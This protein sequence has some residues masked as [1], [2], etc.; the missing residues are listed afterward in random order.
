MLPGD[1]ERVHQ[2]MKDSRPPDAFELLHGH[3]RGMYLGFASEGGGD[4]CGSS[5]DSGGIGT[6][7]T[8]RGEEIVSCPASDVH[9]S[10]LVYRSAPRIAESKCIDG[11][12]KG[13]DFKA[14]EA[15]KF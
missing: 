8:T 12:V 14:S 3:D 15:L 13:G 4:T 1:F 11:C 10:R 5:C 9:P 2:D 6:I 7:S